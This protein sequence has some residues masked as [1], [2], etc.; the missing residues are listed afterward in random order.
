MR[1]VEE[2]RGLAVALVDAGDHE[3]GGE[4]QIELLHEQG[5][6]TR[7]EAALVDGDE[8]CVGARDQS[9]D[10]PAAATRSLRGVCGAARRW[11]SECLSLERRG[12]SGRDSCARARRRRSPAATG[13]EK[14]G[15]ST[16]KSEDVSTMERRTISLLMHSM[17]RAVRLDSMISCGS[18]S[19]AYLR[20]S[21]RPR[22]P[23]HTLLA[24]QNHRHAS[25]VELR[26]T[27]ATDHLLQ[28]GLGDLLV[29]LSAAAP[30]LGALDDHQEHRQIHAER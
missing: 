28:H 18:V 20:L 26:P 27:R 12:D 3:R 21:S 19:F 7:S 4:A 8:V 14:K 23:L 30:L 2:Q 25:L 17:M 11:R 6:E 24:R 5:A 13:G 15:A 10:E 9:D 29:A 16:R 1:Q 22:S